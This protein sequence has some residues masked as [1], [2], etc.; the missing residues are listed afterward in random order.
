MA[1]T[2]VYLITTDKNR[3]Y[4]GSA[5]D[6]HARWRAHRDDLTRDR[7]ANKKL[8]N[9]WNKYGET[10]FT[11]TVVEECFRSN[12][13]IVEQKYLDQNFAEPK[14]CLNIARYAGAP[15]RGRTATEETRRKISAA[16]KGKVISE[17]VKRKMRKPKPQ[18]H[19]EAVSAALTG[20]RH[21][22]ERR[23]KA[24]TSQRSRRVVGEDTA[25][26]TFVRFDSLM[27]A[28]R[29][30]GFDPSHIARCI[31]GE[32]KQHKGFVW[33]DAAAWEA[34]PQ[35]K[36][37]HESPEETA[38]RLAENEKRRRAASRLKYADSDAVRERVKVRRKQ[39]KT[40]A[41]GNLECQAREKE[42]REKNN[43]RRRLRYAN[44]PEYRARVIAKVAEYDKRRKA[45]TTKG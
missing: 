3:R 2:G 4:Y 37:A 10:S 27:A 14:Q 43:V 8:Q 22:P 44:D 5:V 31:Q 29:D 13:L 11:W 16:Q 6:I 23:A 39:R 41:E 28:R 30:G 1:I 45:E 9:C 15:M 7:H 33:R 42:Q 25:T 18:G 12:L 19:G 24:Q 20:V 36:R 17:E 35:S 32:A 34:L 40:L 38:A 21:S 26:G